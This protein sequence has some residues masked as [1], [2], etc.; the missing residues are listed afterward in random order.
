MKQIDWGRLGDRVI[1]KYWYL[2]LA[3][4]LILLVPAFMGFPRL[5][6]DS[7]NDSFMPAGDPVT[8]KNEEFKEIF[9]SKEFFY[10]LIETE[11]LYSRES[12]EKLRELEEDLRENLPFVE[13]ITSLYSAEFME[14]DEGFLRVESLEDQGIPRNPVELAAIREKHL[15]SLL[16]P[17]RIISRDGQSA[18]MLISLKDF[19]ER[20]WAQTEEGYSPFEEEFLQ[21]DKVIL[22]SD[23][24]FEPPTEGHWIELSDPRKDAVASLYALLKDHRSGD[25]HISLTG[26]PYIDYQV[27]VLTE[28][29]TSFFGLLALCAA[30]LLLIFLFRSLR[31]VLAPV[32][33][34]SLTLAYIFGLMPYVKMKVSLMTVILIPLI[35]VISVGYSIHMINRIRTVL[36]RGGISRREALVQAYAHSAWP[37]LLTALTTAAGF[38]SFLFVPIKP[39]R[40]LGV[41]SA[42]GT[43]LAFLLVMV[44]VPLF[45]WP[46]KTPEAKAEKPTRESSFS[47]E[48]WN[49]YIFAR[50]PIIL[51]IFLILGLFLVWGTLYIRPSSDMMETIGEKAAFIRESRYVANRLGGVYSAEFLIELPQEEQGKDPEVLQTLQKAA[52]KAA[53]Y[54]D[55]SLTLSLADLVL[56]L[57][58]I[59]QEK[60]RSLARIPEDSGTLAQYLLLYEMS[61]G[62]TLSDWTDYNYQTLRF[63]VLLKGSSPDF[64]LFG[65]DMLN[66][67]RGELPAGT[68]VTLTGEMPVMMRMMELLTQSQVRS[69]LAALGFIALL[70][71]LI[72]RSIRLGLLAVIPNIFP[73]IVILGLMG[74]LG[75]RLDFVT[76][77]VAPMLIGIAVDDTMHF[78]IHYRQKRQSSRSAREASMRTFKSVGNALVATSVVLTGG[79]V[80]FAFSEMRSLQHLGILASAGI[81]SALAADVLL[82]PL[83]LDSLEGGKNE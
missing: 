14:S 31:A 77:M 45:Y 26:M 64:E 62:S 9:G 51:G 10:L 39:I 68:R 55:V 57:D 83:L 1:L 42:A 6:M 59:L 49:R 27:D 41:L 22:A 21:R 72:L 8:E 36:S 37:C 76:A 35:L 34:F 52:E 54:P 82:S 53:E 24:F 46:G 78:F 58:R 38:L 15:Q 75:Y 19:P 12:L 3:L 18:G 28:K 44:L 73:V 65:E 5:E 13:D 81:I 30:V 25:F 47:W 33:V 70:L 20:V 71:L 17:G 43:M 23:L 69:C 2:W 29:E 63:S 32:L 4:W 74:W 40:N 56:E 60:D 79:F 80:L 61:G 50:K 7:S 16:F 66:Y 48:K 67:F 11:D